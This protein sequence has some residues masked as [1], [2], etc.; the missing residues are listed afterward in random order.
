MFSNPKDTMVNTIFFQTIKLQI[1]LVQCKTFMTDITG[2]FYNAWVIIMGPVPHQLYCLWHVDRARQKNLGKIADKEKQKLVYKTI[3]CLQQ[4]FDDSDFVNRLNTAVN[5]MLE[6]KDT[7]NFGKYF[8]TYYLNNYPFWAYCFRKKYKHVF[9]VC[10]KL[11]NIH[12][13]ETTG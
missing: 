1:E 12:K 9:R 7:E 8:K 6:D 13:S 10:I 4:I 5:H 2:V 11:T 3:K